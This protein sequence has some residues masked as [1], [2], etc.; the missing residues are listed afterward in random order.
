MPRRRRVPSSRARV[1]DGVIVRE[2][3]VPPEAPRR[4]SPSSR[5]SSPARRSSLRLI[6]RG[7]VDD[8]GES[9]RRA[10][11]VRRLR[12]TCDDGDGGGVTEN[13]LPL[14]RVNLDVVV[15]PGPNAGTSV[16]NRRRDAN[17]NANAAAADDDDDA[18][19]SRVS[20]DAVVAAVESRGADGATAEELKALAEELKATSDAKAEP[21]AAS[22]IVAN[23]DSD[24]SE[25]T[26]ALNP[27]ITTS[28]QLA[29]THKRR[30]TNAVFANASV[31]ALRAALR[32]AALGGRICK[33]NGF[34]RTPRYVGV[35]RAARF[36]LPIDQL[37]A[38]SPTISFPAGR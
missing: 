25:T 18:V 31:A 37:G 21:E 15:R 34:P 14:A 38:K 29:Q 2:D 13:A 36:R 12:A 9:P 11:V 30:L 26:K 16:S 28:T 7:G 35:A 22:P 4:C 1:P 33:V 6:T 5:R 17:A 24:A 19:H 20:E 23:P 8:D 27:S 3:P 10:R 32:R